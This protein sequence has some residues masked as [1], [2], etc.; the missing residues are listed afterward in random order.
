MIATNAKA[1]PKANPKANANASARQKRAQSTLYV[2]FAKTFASSE[3]TEHFK[4]F[5]IDSA[6]AL[7]DLIAKKHIKTS[8]ELKAYATSLLQY[9]IRTHL[10]IY[11]KSYYPY[12]TVQSVL[13]I[14]LILNDFDEYKSN[15]EEAITSDGTPPSQRELYIIASLLA[16]MFEHDRIP[17]KWM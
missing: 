2:N 1:N 11:S 17:K 6:F 3:F 4:S 9:D 10:R 14:M 8:C 5:H 15:I 12:I 16:E 13:D 7:W